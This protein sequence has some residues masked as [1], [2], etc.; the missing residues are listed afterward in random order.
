[1]NKFHRSKSGSKVCNEIEV[2]DD[3]EL[4]ESIWADG[5]KIIQ[6]F[7]I[8]TQL[9]GENVDKAKRNELTLLSISIASSSKVKDQKSLDSR[10]IFQSVCGR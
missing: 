7:E 3:R 9:K 8:A 4:L 2:Y 5:S 1:V 10:A 6:Y